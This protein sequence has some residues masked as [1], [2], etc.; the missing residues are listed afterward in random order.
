MTA[1]GHDAIELL[2]RSA[3]DALVCDIAMPDMD[4]YDLIRRVRSRGFS[5]PAI[6]QTALARPEDREQALQAGFQAH[7][8]KPIRY[9]ELI[10][11]LATVG[12][13]HRS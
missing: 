10:A 1:S 8:S 11:M 12:A 2:E 4:G 13:L 9:P 3:F 7:L 5:L 6:A